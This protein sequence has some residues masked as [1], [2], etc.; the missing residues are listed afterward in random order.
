[1]KI[2]NHEFPDAC[3]NNCPFESDN[4]EQDG[5]CHRCPVLHCSGAE[6]LLP[7][8][9]YRTDWVDEWARFFKDVRDNR[10]QI[11]VPVLAISRPA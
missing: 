5:Y 7:P 2:G 10:E 6:P 9:S 3:P 4:F 1:M 8:E 11:Q